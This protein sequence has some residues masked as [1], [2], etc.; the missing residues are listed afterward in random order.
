MSNFSRTPEVMTDSLEILNKFI[1]NLNSIKESLKGR[2]LDGFN[3]DA[4]A[5]LQMA[6]ELLELSTAYMDFVHPMYLDIERHGAFNEEK[7]QQLQSKL[8]DVLVENTKQLQKNFD[9]LTKPRETE[10]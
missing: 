1:S 8:N 7:F 5:L 9:S 10:D 4:I 6:D 3:C 2:K